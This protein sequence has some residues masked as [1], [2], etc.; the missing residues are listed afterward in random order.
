MENIENIGDRLKYLR[1]DILKL[2][3][4]EF[5]ERLLLT[6]TMS[7]KFEK[8]QRT[9]TDR[10]LLDICRE[11]NVNETWLRSGVGEVFTPKSNENIDL[12]CNE[13]NFGEDERFLLERYL[14]LDSEKRKIF[15][16]IAR[17]MLTP[18][19]QLSYEEELQKELDKYEVVIKDTNNKNNAG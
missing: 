11:F 15:S 18:T 19:Q 5:A 4:K 13:F 9:L 7:S 10:T 8:N 3:Q 16:T 2:S 12:L 1:K 17:E 6:D 14:A